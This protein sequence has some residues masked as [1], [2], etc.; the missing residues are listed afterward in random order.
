[1]DTSSEEA[2][3]EVIY[4]LLQT[5][6]KN[7]DKI[8]HG[9]R[10]FVSNALASSAMTTEWLDLYGST[11]MMLLSVW[12]KNGPGLRPQTLDRLLTGLQ[13]QSLLSVHAYLCNEPSE[14]PPPTRCVLDPY[15]TATQTFQD[16]WSMKPRTCSHCRKES[17]FAFVNRQT[18]SA[19]EGMTTFVMCGL[20]GHRHRL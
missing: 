11:V 1:M 5:T 13:D 7:C 8:E 12:R 17:I 9:V 6:R 15:K 20:C 16:L 2:V 4:E 10:A 18:Q 3:V 19:D 14:T